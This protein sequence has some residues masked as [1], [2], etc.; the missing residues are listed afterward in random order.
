MVE[1]DRQ[2]FGEPVA[3]GVLR[4]H[5]RVPVFPA[6]LSRQQAERTHPERVRVRPSECLGVWRSQCLRIR[7]ICWSSRPLQIRVIG[8]EVPRLSTSEVNHPKLL[9]RPEGFEFPASV[10]RVGESAAFQAL[11]PGSDYENRSI[12]NGHGQSAGNANSPDMVTAALTEALNK[13]VAAEMWETAQLIVRQ[14][15]AIRKGAQPRTREQPAKV[16]DLASARALKR[17]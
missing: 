11:T 14:L 3:H 12:P 15:E 8:S 7:S 2:G 17:S 9:A 16:L 1:L 5:Q 10:Q 6:A 4:A 13:A